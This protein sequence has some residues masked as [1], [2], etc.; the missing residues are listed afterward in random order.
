MTVASGGLSTL[1]CYLQ[2]V[3][4]VNL[5]HQSASSNVVITL[6]SH[7]AIIDGT[8]V[9]VFGCN[10]CVVVILDVLPHCS[11]AASVAVKHAYFRRHLTSGFLFSAQVSS[12]AVLVKITTCINSSSLYF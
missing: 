3:P 9:L 4:S 10:A 2:A 1:K 7:S 5:F 12:R 6:S 8:L 11:L